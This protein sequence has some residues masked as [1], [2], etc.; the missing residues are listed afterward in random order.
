[1]ECRSIGCG[2]LLTGELGC[3]S[4]FAECNDLR[5]ELEWYVFYLDVIGS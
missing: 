3:Q 4:H 5:L 1:V 2:E